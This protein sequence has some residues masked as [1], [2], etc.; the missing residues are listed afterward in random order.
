MTWSFQ[1]L[2][3]DYGFPSSVFPRKPLVDNFN[4]PKASSSNTITLQTR[5]A[6]STSTTCLQ[7]ENAT[8]QGK[9]PSSFPAT[10]KNAEWNTKPSEE[11]RCFPLTSSYRT[12]QTEQE[13]YRKAPSFH[14]PANTTYGKRISSM[15]TISRKSSVPLFSPLP[16]QNETSLHLHQLQ[17]DLKASCVF[18]PFNVGAQSQQI[19]LKNFINVSNKTDEKTK[20]TVQPEKKVPKKSSNVPIFEP[21]IP[22]PQNQPLNFKTHKDILTKLET[23][24]PSKNSKLAKPDKKEKVDAFFVE[25]KLRNLKL[26]HALTEPNSLSCSFADFGQSLHKVQP[27]KKFTGFFDGPKELMDFNRL[28]QSFDDDP[29]RFARA[30]PHCI[31][32]AGTL[33]TYHPSKS[34]AKVFVKRQSLT[35]YPQ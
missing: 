10:W 23:F 26:S 5:W 30:S 33:L 22:S 6:N 19:V 35:N 11:A 16:D 13:I 18:Q 1:L 14:V 8:P 12:V 21:V 20:E 9:N 2:M 7:R 27:N 15:E 31:Q 3:N 34:P 4:T 32:S 25:P 28:D 24:H 17:T 29:A